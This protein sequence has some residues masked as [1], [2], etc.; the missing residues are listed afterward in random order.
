MKTLADAEFLRR[1]I[2]GAL[3]LVDQTDDLKVREQ[4]LTF[5]LVGAVETPAAAR[6]KPAIRRFGRFCRRVCTMRVC[7]DAAV[8]DGHARLDKRFTCAQAL[9]PR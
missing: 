7:P 6:D 9:L 2:M 5:V 1:R 3:E 4:L 8:A